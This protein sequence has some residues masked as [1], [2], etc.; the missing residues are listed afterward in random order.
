MTPANGGKTRE[1]V[2]L[3]LFKAGNKHYVAAACVDD[4][5]EVVARD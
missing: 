3:L 1:A 2:L 5:A 4:F